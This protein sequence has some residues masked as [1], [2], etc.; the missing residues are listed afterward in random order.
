MFHVSE[1]FGLQG[2][3]SSLLASTWPSQQFR[4]GFFRP[5]RE[6]L[7]FFFFFWRLLSGNPTVEEVERLEVHICQIF[8]L[9]H[10]C[11][12]TGLM[13]RHQFQL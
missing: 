13:K 8:Q 10:V 2:L 1:T 3:K 12:W 4:L 6:T 5:G 11:P 9:Q 7:F